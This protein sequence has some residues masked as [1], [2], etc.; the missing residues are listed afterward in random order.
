MENH[1]NKT[2]YLLYTRIIYFATHTESILKLY[3]TK[4]QNTRKTPNLFKLKKGKKLIHQRGT[5]QLRVGR[6][7]PCSD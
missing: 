6:Y 3:I 2:S 4:I 1:L 5:A 7:F